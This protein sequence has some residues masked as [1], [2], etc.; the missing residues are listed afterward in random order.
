MALTPPARLRPPVG[1]V[2]MRPGGGAFSDPWSRHNQ[3]IADRLADMPA[4]VR[5]GVV[6]GSDAAAG[7][8]GEYVAASFAGP[9]SLPSI[10]P[11]NVG[12]LALTAGDWDVT[13]HVI[14]TSSAGNMTVAQSWVSEV[15]ATPPAG[16]G[17][18][19]IV[20]VGGSMGTATCLEAGP[21]RVSLAA[22]ATVYLGG[23]A[24]Y[25]SGSVTAAGAIAAR[26]M[27]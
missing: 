25:A 15:S 21:I 12:T 13:G 23:Y 18:T 19:L 4:K 8:I 3:D 20:L 9:V 2:P 16:L 27:R 5:K 17:R 6:D 26:R 24:Q 1:E 10:T 14:Y 22:P 7:D 11:T